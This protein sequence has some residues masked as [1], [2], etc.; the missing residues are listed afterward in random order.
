MAF[1]V[2]PAA[3][4]M[5]KVEMMLVGM[6][7]CVGVVPAVAVQQ[8]ASASQTVCRMCRV[9]AWVMDDMVAFCVVGFCGE[10]YG[11]PVML[12]GAGGGSGGRGT[13]RTACPPGL[14]ALRLD[15]R[16]QRT[17]SA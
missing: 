11:A 2:K 17:A 7:S 12:S 16:A 8:R 10:V 4:M 13:L 14:A 1:S 5:P 9:G 15:L 6:S 3:R